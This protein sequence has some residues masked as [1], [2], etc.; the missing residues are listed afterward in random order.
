MR[1]LITIALSG[2][3]FSFSLNAADAET[4][5]VY[6]LPQAAL[7][8]AVVQSQDQ[9]LAYS[10]GMPTALSEADGGW[11][12]P[13]PGIARWRLRFFSEG[14]HNLSLHLENLRLPPGAELWLR[15]EG[16]G[17]VQGPFTQ[18]DDTSLWLPLVRADRALLEVRMPLALQSAFGLTVSDV[19]HGFRAFMP[20]SGAMSKGAIGDSEG[21]CHNDVACPIANGWRDQIR[22]TVLI[23]IVTTNL[24]LVSTQSL[25]S[26]VLVNNTQ[27]DERPLIL[28]ANH[29]GVDGSSV[30][31][32]TVYF[33]VQKNICGGSADG[34]VNMNIMGK[35]A[36]SSNAT[37]D[38]SLFELQSKPPK[39]FD[40]Y[41]AGVDARDVAPQ[42]GSGIHHPG[43]DDKKISFYSTPGVKRS[44]SIAGSGNVNAWEIV[45][46]NAAT[47]QGSSGSGLWNQ[48]RRVVGVLSGGN[49][50]CS[51]LSGTDYYGRLENAWTAN[52]NLRQQLDPAGT[53]ALVFDGRN[54]GSSGSVSSGPGGE[55]ASYASGNGGGGAWPWTTLAA[56]LAL[57]GLRHRRRRTGSADPGQQRN[58]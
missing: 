11:D 22:S 42:S 37:S 31:N 2:L 27:Q 3:V 45:W 18:P 20:T 8:A 49:S 39:S 21:S 19:F 46:S 4:V 44:A 26:G 30:K 28:T 33:N 41:Y 15:A 16:G 35:S 51:N 53:G 36:L 38:Y 56:M 1:K 34:P 24:L 52:G 43:G 14:A 47:E 10:V 54:A 12:E 29:C 50:S 7:A 55:A 25:C 32:T 23:S 5:P 48:D 13:E 17:D 6:S 57:Y 9:P 58:I 40:V